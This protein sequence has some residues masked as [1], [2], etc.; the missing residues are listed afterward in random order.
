[1]TIYAN[2]VALISFGRKLTGVVLE[3]EDIANTLRCMFSL[4]WEKLK[5]G[6]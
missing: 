2:K 4:L 3:S 6:E 5:K 1:M